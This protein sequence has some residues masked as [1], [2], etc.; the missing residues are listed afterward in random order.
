[1]NNNSKRRKALLAKEL[2]GKYGKPVTKAKA[3]PFPRPNKSDTEDIRVSLKHQAHLFN[4]IAC[5]CRV[6]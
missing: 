2:K 6:N 4:G 3:K 1:M 5:D